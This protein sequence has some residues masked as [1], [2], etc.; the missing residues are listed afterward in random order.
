MRKEKK[1]VTEETPQATLPKTGTADPMLFSG[2]G[3]AL[4]GLGLLLKKKKEDTDAFMVSNRSVDF[5]MGAAIVC[6]ILYLAEGWASV[7]L[8]RHTI[9]EF[10][11]GTIVA[12]LIFAV[13]H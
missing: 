9:K 4:L 5:G 1:E 8:K 7:E 2:L 10:L 13:I 11:G 3:G 12:C 6:L